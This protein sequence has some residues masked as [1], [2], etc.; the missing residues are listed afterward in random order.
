M[1]QETL[2]WQPILGSKLAKSDYSLLFVA[3]PFRNELKYHYSDFKKFTYD[4]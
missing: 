3:T 2:P 4:D 1:A